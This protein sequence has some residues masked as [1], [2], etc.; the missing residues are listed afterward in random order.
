MLPEDYEIIA[1]LKI[2]PTSRQDL[3]GWH[4]TDG[5]YTVKSGYWV[6]T[7]LPGNNLVQPTYG[8]TSLKQQVWKTKVPSKLHQF[9][10]RLLS[11]S[12]ATGNNLKRRYITRDVIGKRCFQVEETESPKRVMLDSRIFSLTVDLQRKFKELQGLH[13]LLLIILMQH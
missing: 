13:M 5:I 4:N 3:V 2:S 6:A 11:K 7:H 9:L 1:A 10:W 12:L 8:N